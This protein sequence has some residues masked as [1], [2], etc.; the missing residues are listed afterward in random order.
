ML[1][2]KL[3]CTEYKDIRLHDCNGYGLYLSN[4]KLKKISYCT[5]FGTPCTEPIRLQSSSYPD[6]VYK[7]IHVI[8]LRITNIPHLLYTI[9]YSLNCNSLLFIFLSTAI[10]DISVQDIC[11]KIIGSSGRKFN[12]GHKW[13]Q[14]EYGKGQ[15]RRRK[16]HFEKFLLD[17]CLYVA[18]P[19]IGLPDQRTLDGENYD[20]M[21]DEN[22]KLSREVSALKSELLEKNNLR[23]EIEMRLIHER[24]SFLRENKNLNEKVMKLT[25]ELEELKVEHRETLMEL[26]EMS[27]VQT[28][29]INKTSDAKIF[30]RIFHTA[31]SPPSTMENCEYNSFLSSPMIGSSEHVNQTQ[32][33]SSQM[34]HVLHCLPSTSQTKPARS[35]GGEFSFNARGMNDQTKGG[36]SG[37]LQSNASHVETHSPLVPTGET[38][39]SSAE[40]LSFPIQVNQLGEKESINLTDEPT[41]SITANVR[42]NYKLLLITVADSLLAGNSEKLREW[43]NDHYSIEPNASATEVI[44]ELDKKGVINAF[45]LS[46]LRAFLESIVRH[47]LVFLIDEFCAGDYTSLRR[48]IHSVCTRRDRGAAYVSSR[49]LSSGTSNTGSTRVL[50]RKRPNIA[51]TST[52]NVSDQRSRETLTQNH[53]KTTSAGFTGAVAGRNSDLVADGQEVNNTRGLFQNSK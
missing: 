52:S 26:G 38:A 6:L 1:K 10:F 4:A 37:Q 48:L 47:D 20:H 43:A 9:V 8:F 24:E 50:E 11:Q 16:Y 29:E 7:R 41:S 49:P 12:D 39:A 35:A 25:K 44:F 30:Q 32:A 28:A 51:N 31:K 13:K 3:I 33:S 36:E 53:P 18:G 42:N 40:N 34:V 23:H 2:F 14:L 22:E 21:E 5:F 17:L 15:I 46:E 19:T 45:D 27:V